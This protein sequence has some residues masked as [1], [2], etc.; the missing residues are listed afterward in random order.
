MRTATPDQ[1][2]TLTERIEKAT[3]PDRG[4]DGLIGALI[5]GGRAAHEFT[6]DHPGARAR[7][8]YGE[9][10]VFFNADPANN[11]GHILM[12]HYTTMPPLTASLDAITALIERELPGWTLGL[13]S[14]LK[15]DATFSHAN[16]WLSRAHIST[17]RPA[18]LTAQAATLA[19][20]LCAAF[21]RAMAERD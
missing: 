16:T 10:A 12:E 13:H 11:G 6:E 4:I 21:C 2:I 9:G 18:L 19:L 7:R 5:H 3:G 20:A 17:A 14:H 15:Y 8:S 1:W